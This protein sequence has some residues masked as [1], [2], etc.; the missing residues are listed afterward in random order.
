VRRPAKMIAVHDLDALLFDAGGVFVLPDP[1]V[2]GPLLVYY[3]GDPSIDAHVRA[4]YRGMAAKS[5]AGSGEAFWTEYDRAY[6]RAVGVPA[7]DVEPAAATLGRTRT[8][9]LWRWPIPDSVTA[10]RAMHAAG[11]PIGVVSNASGQIADVLRRSGVCQV[12]RG[13]HTPVRVIVDS[14]VVGV[15]K[16]D[17]AI[18]EHALHVFEGIARSR[19]GYVGDSV[20][21]DIVGARAAGLAPIL[22]DPYDDHPDADFRRIRSLLDIVVDPHT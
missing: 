14:H 11:V 12:G 4:H 2:L 6:V 1:T 17:P 5:A 16:P 21:M 13:D 19:I 15:A 18:F 7:P 10:L 22:L 20:T 8:A 3:G 9:A